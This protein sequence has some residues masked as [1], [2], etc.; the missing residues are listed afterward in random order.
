MAS[1]AVR[2]DRKD[3]GGGAD[4]DDGDDCDADDVGDGGDECGGCDRYG[5]EHDDHLSVTTACSPL[6]S[7]ITTSSISPPPPSLHLYR[8]HRITTVVFIALL[9]S[10][11]RH[12]RH[13]IAITMPSSH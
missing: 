4:D 12:H 5:A 11:P 8:N 1:R 7:H 3:D 9:A 6:Y 2:G 10:Y 13:H